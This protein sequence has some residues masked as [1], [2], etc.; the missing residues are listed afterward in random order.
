MLMYPHM[1]TDCYQTTRPVEIKT[2]SPSRMKIK[3]GSALPALL[4][5]GMVLLG[6]GWGVPRCAAGVGFPTAVTNEVTM[7]AAVFQLVIDPGFTN[8][9]YPVEQFDILSRLQSGQWRVD[10]SHAVSISN[11]D[12]NE[13]FACA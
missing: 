5:A 1:K 9:F 3:F 7:S 10:Q 12:W 2:H 13:R 11:V 8:L 4:L 6:P